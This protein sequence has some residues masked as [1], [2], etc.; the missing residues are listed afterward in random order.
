MRA[1]ASG[2][3]ISGAE[4]IVR[5]RDIPVAT[6]Q[7]AQRAISHE[8]GAPDTIHITVERV[9]EPITHIE[10]LPITTVK[11]RSH[12]EAE[13]LALIALV[14]SGV[15][16]TVAHHAL[17]LIQR[18]PAPEGGNMRGAVIMH[19]ESGERLEPD[20]QRGVRATRMDMSED[21]AESLKRQLLVHGLGERADVIREALVLASKV[22]HF[23]TVAEV[24]VSDNPSN[25]VGYVASKTLG[26]LRIPHLKSK[27]SAFNGGRVFF[28]DEVSGLQEYIEYLEH[29]PVIIHRSGGIRS[30][31]PSEFMKEMKRGS[32]DIITPFMKNNRI[33][34]EKILCRH[35][36]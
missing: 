36:N 12:K 4:R 31:T 19:R 17:R 6:E 10:A 33:K 32:T 28:V 1:S 5:E 18:G 21:A 23:Q 16:P 8:R 9:S 2:K 7:L 14:N 30:I 15:T 22:A 27:T 11:T 29:T 3:H 24:C 26:F 35:R 13:K 34:E 25:H 20:N